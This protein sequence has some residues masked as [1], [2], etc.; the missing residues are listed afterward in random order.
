[1]TNQ[2]KIEGDHNRIGGMYLADEIHFHEKPLIDALREELVHTFDEME[3]IF[4]EL[5]AGEKLKLRSHLV[6]LRVAV[7]DPAVLQWVE[8][9]VRQM[10]CLDDPERR[11][12]L[13]KVKKLVQ[14]F[15]QLHSAG[16]KYNFDREENWAKVL[17]EKAEQKRNFELFNPGSAIS[18][19]L[20]VMGPEVIR[21]L[22][23]HDFPLDRDDLVLLCRKVNAS[24]MSCQKECLEQAGVLPI[25]IQNFT[26]VDAYREQ[27]PN[28]F[29]DLSR[30]QIRVTCGTCLVDIYECELGKEILERMFAL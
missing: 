11:D 5:S 10:T 21:Y 1:M 24:R 8:D 25:V 22:L 12:C 19:S 28:F 6:K 2:V 18:R 20:K 15:L 4:E 17:S 16:Y 7:K 9:K 14:F 23:E 27:K 30:G 3:E 29:D 13:D 26:E